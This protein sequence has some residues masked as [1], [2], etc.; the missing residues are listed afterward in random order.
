MCM[1]ASA[2]ASLHCFP[3]TGSISW[4]QSSSMA[5][6]RDTSEADGQSAGAGRFRTRLNP[7][8]AALVGGGST[9]SHRVLLAGLLAIAVILPFLVGSNRWITLMTVVVIY[10][11]LALSLIH[12]SEPTRRT[13]ISY[14]VFCLKKKKK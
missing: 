14:A 9:K 1:T 3:W 6:K 8:A 12:I 5:G 13:P 4:N 10:I 7:I 11:V 2:S